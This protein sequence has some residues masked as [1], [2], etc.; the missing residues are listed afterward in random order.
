M[1]ISALRRA[2][3][4]AAA[5]RGLLG[6]GRVHGP[7]PSQTHLH[8]AE[9]SALFSSFSS[10][11]PGAAADAHLFR[12]INF[13]ISCAQQDCKKSDWAKE[14]GE[15]FPFEIQDKE[16]ASRIILTR[17]DQKERIEVEV[18]LPSPV[19]PEEQNE[20]YQAE[21]DNR[22]SR[23]NSGV[24]NQYCIPLMVKIHKGVASWL[25]IS[26]SSYP[27]K[28]VIESLA[29][30][31]NSASVDSLNVEA[32]IRNLPEKLQ[33][34]FYSYLKSRGISTDVANFL[35]AYMINKECHEYLSWLR[36]LK[37][38]IKS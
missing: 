19:D 14:L 11:Q 3:W 26:C 7:R 34:A 5:A 25:E 6:S 9:R 13:E 36:K 30:G 33:R 18:F 1:A 27:N 22:P 32:K 37:G 29:F 2:P 20:E 38:L 28:L 21:D 10:P 17:R 24:S 31:P 4:A 35:H 23:A 12:V 16:G 8:R 15:G